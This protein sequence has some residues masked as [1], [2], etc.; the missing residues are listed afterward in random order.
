MAEEALTPAEA[1][2][3][4]CDLAVDARAAV[5]LDGAGG[6][7]AGSED[8]PER[9]RELAELAR[10]LVQAADAAAAREPT[11]A[12]EAQTAGGSVYAVRRV[13]WT[14]VAVARR[15]ALPSL[16]LYDMRV[17]LDRVAG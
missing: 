14:L 3:Y 15:S 5:L 8:R 9:N 7:A 17:V 1:P 12:L 16:M 11:E 6:L 2:R 4:L 10:E 13:G